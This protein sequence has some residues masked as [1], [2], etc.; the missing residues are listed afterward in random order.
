MWLV[1]SDW[2]REHGGSIRSHSEG[3]FSQ[4]CYMTRIY[5]LRYAT[6]L[7]FIFSYMLKK[8]KKTDQGAIYSQRGRF[9]DGNLVCPSPTKNKAWCNP[10]QRSHLYPCGTWKVGNW[11]DW[12]GEQHCPVVLKLT[13][14]VGGQR[15]PVASG[16][17]TGHPQPHSGGSTVGGLS[18]RW[19]FALC[20]PLDMHSC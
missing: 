7:V 11:T 15:P 18:P 5:F 17:W 10:I 8:E 2:E 6:W 4:I 16:S 12:P 3:L 9:Q 20:L 1:D 13:T 14:E 19:Y